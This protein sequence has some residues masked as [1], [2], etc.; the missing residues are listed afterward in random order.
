MLHH[1]DVTSGSSVGVEAQCVAV[2][3][4]AAH[5][6]RG[7]GGHR[8]AHV[9]EVGMPAVLLLGYLGGPG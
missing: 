3:N 6:E 5:L 2:A 4:A 8:C 7:L 1:L 9:K